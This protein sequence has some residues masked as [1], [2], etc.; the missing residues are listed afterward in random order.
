MR[1]SLRRVVALSALALTV[2]HAGAAIIFDDDFNG[3]NAGIGTLNY[4][5]FPKWS[6]TSGTVDLI[7]NGFY[8]FLPG[9][10]LFIDLDGSTSDAGLFSTGDFSLTPGTYSV[11]FSL[12]GN[13]RGGSDDVTVSFGDWSHTYNL[14]ANDPLTTRTVEV[15]VPQQ[16]LARLTFQNSGG[17]NVGALLDDVRISSVPSPTGVAMMGL[18]GAGLILRRGR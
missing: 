17:D 11:S 16:R 6:V 18:L 8:D 4:A 12:A 2:P 15:V 9:Q 5:S 10:G 13:H 1:Q 14:L 7:G 3:E